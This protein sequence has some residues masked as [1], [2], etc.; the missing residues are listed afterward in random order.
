MYLIINL[1]IVVFSLTKAGLKVIYS[2]LLQMSSSSTRQI[3]VALYRRD[4]I[5]TDPRKRRLY[6]HESYHWGILIS[7]GDDVYDSYD[8]TDTNTI[9]PITFRQE[10]PT[11]GWW[12]RAIQGADPARSGR[13]L[14]RIIIGS[15]P[16]N[17]SRDDIQLFLDNVPL[18]E[19]NKHPQQSCVTWV[20]NAIRTF[21]EAQW[22]ENF[23]V[24]D[25]LDWALDYADER[26][27]NP[28]GVPD[29]VHYE[30]V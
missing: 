13:L 5:S 19:R 12:F 14:G 30:K 6:Q 10:N 22:V 24:R 18:P 29:T 11:L 3:S 17:K 21:H 9:D 4:P 1:K 23:N 27:G 26:L 28:G 25:F 2:S 20:G 7:Q 8:A 15:V 16:S